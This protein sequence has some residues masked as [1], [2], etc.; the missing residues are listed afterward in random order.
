VCL[1]GGFDVFVAARPVPIPAS[2]ERLVALLALHEQ[3]LHR[4]YVSGMLWPDAS[5]ERAGGNLRSVLWRLRRAG[6]PLVEG[7]N[8]RL[9]LGGEI[10]VDVDD[11]IELILRAR[12]PG[13]EIHDDDVA[14]I[15]APAELLPGWDEDWVVVERERFRQ[16]RLHGL[17]T[18]CARLSDEKRFGAAVE[19]GLAALREEPLRESGQIAL[20]RAFLAEGN[21][22]E[23]VRQFERY[24]ALLRA[25]LGLEPSLELERLLDAG[26]SS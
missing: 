13:F 24:R 2:A 23:A 12:D 10:S 11:R 7:S 20:I 3:P 21:A 6:L 22:C 18:F 16:L 4:H 8:R 26:P 1:L 15:A 17:E 9:A 25:E 19:T 14:L 5:E